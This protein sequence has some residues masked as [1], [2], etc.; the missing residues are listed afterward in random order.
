M[1]HVY[2]YLK[3]F[4]KKYVSEGVVFHYVYEYVHKIVYFFYNIKKVTIT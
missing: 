3:L 1:F 2:S 4:D